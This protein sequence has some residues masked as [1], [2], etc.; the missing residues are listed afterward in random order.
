MRTVGHLHGHGAK[1]VD[2]LAGAVEKGVGEEVGG[3]VDD[4]IVE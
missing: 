1:H 2:V 3:E 4:E